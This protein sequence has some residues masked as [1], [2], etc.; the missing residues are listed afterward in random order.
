MLED[1]VE[2]MTGVLVVF[3]DDVLRSQAARLDSILTQKLRDSLQSVSSLAKIALE[4]KSDGQQ[5]NC[6]MFG[7]RHHH[8]LV[9]PK[10]PLPAVADL[11]AH[12]HEAD[13]V[14]V[15]S[16]GADPLANAD[17]G[18]LGSIYFAENP[19]KLERP[20]P[21]ASTAAGPPDHRPTS[22]ANIFGNGWSSDVP[23]RT[24][25]PP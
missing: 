24:V 9:F 23:F 25:R 18:A 2:K 14:S 12:L 4:S 3:A 16:K 5:D 22:L 13:D 17:S 10:T 11:A 8:S 7:R 1:T 19:E 15:A 21:A 20:S 6:G